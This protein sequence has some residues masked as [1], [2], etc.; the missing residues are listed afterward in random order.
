MVDDRSTMLN[1]CYDNMTKTMGFANCAWPNLGADQSRPQSPRYPCPAE[2]ENEDKD[3]GNEGSG[4]EIGC[5]PNEC[6]W[7]LGMR[8][9]SNSFSEQCRHSSSLLIWDLRIGLWEFGYKVLPTM[10]YVSLEKSLNIFIMWKKTFYYLK[11]IVSCR[12]INFRAGFA[13]DMLLS[14]YYGLIDLLFSS[15][16]YI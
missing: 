5:W 14:L 8:M 4:D 15:N 9:T 13:V 16:S 1:C 10:K 2:R 11:S 7:V 6:F 3:K 12:C